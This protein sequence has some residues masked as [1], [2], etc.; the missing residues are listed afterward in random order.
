[1]EGAATSLTQTCIAREALY[2]KI[3]CF[4]NHILLARAK[5]DQGKVVLFWYTKTKTKRYFSKVDPLKLNQKLNYNY[6]FTVHTFAI[7]ASKACHT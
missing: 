7:C 6:L 4:S 1:M 5:E 3:M 2:L